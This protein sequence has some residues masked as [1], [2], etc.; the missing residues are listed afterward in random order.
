MTKPPKRSSL[1]ASF[2]LLAADI[3]A[4]PKMNTE[5]QAPPRGLRAWALESSVP[6]HKAISDLR[7][8]RD[9]LLAMLEAG[10]GGST[11]IDAPV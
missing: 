2:G 5:Q 7:G 4:D 10:S 6:L 11:E 8:E 1:A 3:N 9:R